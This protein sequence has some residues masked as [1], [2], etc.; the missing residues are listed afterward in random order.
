[1]RHLTKQ[2]LNAGLDGIRQS[3]KDGGS[4]DLIVRRPETEQREVL[5]EGRLDT[6]H[7]LVGDNWRARGN[8]STT[9]GKADPEMQLTIMNSRVIALV[10]QDPQRWALAGDQLYIDMDLSPENLPPGTKLS[11][12]SAIIEVTAPPHTGCKKF[13]ARFGKDAMIFVN[14]GIGRQL[15]LRGINAR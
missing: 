8:R 14:S 13:V 12:G 3:P 6:V 10:A 9:D 4:L 7:G 2:E 5:S 1:M 15:N 11:I